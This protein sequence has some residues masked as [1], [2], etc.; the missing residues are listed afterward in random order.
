PLGRA[1]VANSVGHGAR[2]PRYDGEVCQMIQ[3]FELK[4]TRPMELHDGVVSTTTDVWIM[5]TASRDGDRDR[6]K[7]LAQRCPALLTCEY[8]YTSPLHFSVRE[9]HLDVVRYLVEQGALDPTYKTH[10][11]LESLVTVA[12]DRGHGEIAELLKRSLDDPKLTR[13]WG[14]TGKIVYGKDETQRRFQEFVDKNKR[15][16]VEAM[17]KERPELAL[18]EDTFWGE[19]VLSMPAKDGNRQMLELLIRYGARVPDLS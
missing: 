6:V 19:G 18:D 9:G 5:L 1:E 3:P 15:A 7:E 4:E 2:F 8:D 13:A 10:P 14:D 11:F 12:D 16:E 17:L